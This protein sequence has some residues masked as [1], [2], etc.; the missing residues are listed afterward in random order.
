MY[1]VGFFFYV[2]RRPFSGI[3]NLI[4]VVESRFQLGLLIS[5][6]AGSETDPRELAWLLPGFTF[7]VWAF[8]MSSLS[9]VHG[10]SPLL[11]LAAGFQVWG[12]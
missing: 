9:V 1:H 4:P 7:G 12:V 8:I 6:A 3:L 2:E 5:L 10:R 11:S